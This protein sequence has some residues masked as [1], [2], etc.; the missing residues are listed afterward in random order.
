MERPYPIKNIC[1]IG[2]GYVGGPTM[3]V[4]ANNCPNINVYVADINQDRISAWNNKD[5][6]KLP[7]YEP[8]LEKLVEKLRGIN[9]FFTTDIKNSISQA[10]MIFLS[11]NT[12]LKVKGSELAKL[13]ILDG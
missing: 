4:I 8:G 13:V 12:L 1:C 2:A 7:V 6:K 10:D 3:T 5:L 11:V 9:L